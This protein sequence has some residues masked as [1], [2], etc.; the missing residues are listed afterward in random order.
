MQNITPPPLLLIT[1]VIFLLVP[2]NT[3][4]GISLSRVRASCTHFYEKRPKTTYFFAAVA[5]YVFLQKIYNQCDLIKRKYHLCKWE[6]QCKKQSTSP[7]QPARSDRPTM[8][9]FAHG[10]GTP[11]GTSHALAFWHAFQG[12]MPVIHAPDFSD[13]ADSGRGQCRPFKTCMGQNG[14]ARTLAQ[15]PPQTSLVVEQEVNV[16]VSRG[17]AATINRL[18]FGAG[19]YDPSRIKCVILDVPMGSFKS[20]L[21]DIAKKFYVGY[22]PGVPSLIHKVLGLVFPRYR[23]WGLEAIDVVH[24][25][26][27]HIPLLFVARWNDDLVGPKDNAIALYKVARKAGLNAHLL[28]LPHG[29]HN[30]CL[31]ERMSGCSCNDE[32]PY[33]CHNLYRAVVTAMY[34]EYGAPYKEN[35]L[36]PGVISKNLLQTLCK[37]DHTLSMDALKQHFSTQNFER[38]NA[39]MFQND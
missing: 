31:G 19:N 17:G 14:N 22:I 25:I 7:Q 20:V 12:D 21:T 5:T 34:Q 4:A 3:Q 16:G 38:L 1:V 13:A 24:L 33:A 15:N 26:P 36:Y 2:K 28:I 8:Y 9:R 37:P 35:Y 11:S 10:F 6:T 30:E 32:L 39:Q 27:K 29:G 18:A 23:S